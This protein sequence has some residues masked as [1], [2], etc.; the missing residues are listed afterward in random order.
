[1]DKT[2]AGPALAQGHHQSGQRHRRIVGGAHG[3]TDQ[4]TTAPIEHARDVQPA[5]VGRHVSQ[6][7]HPDLIRL[8][9]GRQRREPIGRKRV[10]VSAV[11]G[12]HAIPVPL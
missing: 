2:A 3:P 11:G 6:I 7:A 10:R 1:M 8:G 12:A 9:R 5:F 4:A